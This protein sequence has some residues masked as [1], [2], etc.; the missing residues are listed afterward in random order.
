[1]K[2]THSSRTHVHKHAER[3]HMHARKHTDT[4]PITRKHPPH[5]LIQAKANIF[6]CTCKKTQTIELQHIIL[7]SARNCLHYSSINGQIT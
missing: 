7:S 5:T 1:M 6:T 3:E 4:Y 2:D